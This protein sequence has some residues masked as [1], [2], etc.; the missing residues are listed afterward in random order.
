MKKKIPDKNVSFAEEEV[1]RKW[2]FCKSKPLL[3]FQHIVIH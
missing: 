2:K 3:L 1:T